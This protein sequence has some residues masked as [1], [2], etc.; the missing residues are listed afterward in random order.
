MIAANNKS[1]IAGMRQRFFVKHF[2]SLLQLLY[3]C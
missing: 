1:L 2:S 3:N